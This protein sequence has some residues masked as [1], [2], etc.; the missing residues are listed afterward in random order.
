MMTGVEPAA[1]HPHHTARS[2][3]DIEIVP[4][5]LPFD[6]GRLADEV[7][8]LEA[9]GA[10]RIQFDVMDGQFVPNITFGPDV[11][12]ACRQGTTIPFEA[13]LM[14]LTPEA[15]LAQWV[16]AGCERLI[17]H[18]ESTI[19]V[20]RTLAAVHDLGAAASIAINPSTPAVAVE[21]V[22]DL[23]DQVL[24]MTVNPGFGGQPYIATMEP[25]IRQVG[26]LI[27]AAGRGREVAIEV[28]GGIGPDTIVGAATAG[29]TKLV[30]GTSLT[31]HPGGIAEAI[32]ELRK[33]AAASA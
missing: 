1:P 31:R 14:V 10:D 22:L 18:L 5:V 4:S 2:V 21:H 23:V 27:D 13:H 26:A 25:K 8:K 19:H 17:V 32:A 24:V 7:A 15:M 11:V 6:Q 30:A 16:E 33:L 29:A 28:D 20:H 12:A 3:R 9:A